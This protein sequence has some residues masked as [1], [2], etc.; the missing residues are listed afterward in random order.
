LNNKI[1]NKIEVTDLDAIKVQ[2][3]SFSTAIINNTRPLVPIDD[4]YKA[5]AVANK[6]IDQL[7]LNVNFATSNT[8]IV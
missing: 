6:I 4:G 8:I 2:L 1:L 7:S 3:E 5:I